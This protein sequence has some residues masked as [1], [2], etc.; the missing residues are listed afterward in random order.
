[1]EVTTMRIFV[2]ASLLLLIPTAFADAGIPQSDARAEINRAQ[3]EYR[4][5]LLDADA[6][7][8]AKIWSDDYTFTNSRGMFLSKDD[9]LQ[10][11]QTSA[12]EFKSIKFTDREVQFYGDV[13]IVTG[14]VALEAKYSGQGGSGDYRY[15]NVWV[16][17]GGRWQ[18][19]ANQITPIVE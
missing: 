13:A 12:T 6:S 5:A 16:K 9:R 19:A 1:M 17:R 3:A 4:T 2:L 14:Q 11:I 15:I 8:L 10:N 7:A 18:M